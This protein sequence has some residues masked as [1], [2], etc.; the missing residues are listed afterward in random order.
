MKFAKWKQKVKTNVEKWSRPKKKPSQVVLEYQDILCQIEK[1]MGKRWTKDR[2]DHETWQWRKDRSISAESNL[3]ELKR[4]IECAFCSRS[5]RELGLNF[6]TLLA[7]GLPAFVT[8][9]FG[10]IVLYELFSNP[11][12]ERMHEIIFP[13]SLFPRNRLNDLE[14]VSMFGHHLNDSDI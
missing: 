4:N 6:S 7:T 1:E 14:K 12:A 8:K 13:E 9:N 11:D 5:C 10:G 2:R 3:N